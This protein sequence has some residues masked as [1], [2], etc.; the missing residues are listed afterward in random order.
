MNKK[1]ISDTGPLISLSECCLLWL[2]P[3]IKPEIFIPPKVKEE[4]VDKPLKTK[5]FELKAIR[6]SKFVEEMIE[7]VGE[8]EVKK[9]ARRLSN[10]ANSLFSHKG[11]NLSIVHGGEAEMVA[12]LKEMDA[13]AVML[14]ERT[15]RLLIEDLNMLQKYLEEKHKFQIDMDEDKAKK[16]MEEFKNV[17]VIRSSEIVAYAYEQGLLDRY[18]EPEKVLEAALYGVR[19][20]GCSISS[21]E[22]KEYL[23]FMK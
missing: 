9:E 11:K 14:D 7:V 22:I 20:A 5:K 19:F 1:I 21:E 15:T 17:S 10:M 13:H 18:G 3:E 12:L 16:I 23:S 6:L 8:E 4:L 2:I